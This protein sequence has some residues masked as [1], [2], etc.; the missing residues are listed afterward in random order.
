MAAPKHTKTL[1]VRVR[2]RHAPK[3]RAM[4]GHVNLVWNYCNELTDR[5]WRERRQWPS[6]FDLA[7]YLAGSTEFLQI[8]SATID[9]V[10]DVHGK[11]RRQQRKARLRWRGRRSLGWVPFK[12]RGARFRNGQVHFNGLAFKVWDSY[13]LSGYDF[14]AGAFVEDARGRWYFTV[15]VDVPE[16]YPVGDRQPIGIDLGASTTATP[17][18]GPKCT[19]TRPMRRSAAKLARIQRRVGTRKRGQRI[20]RRQRQRIAA[21][22]AKVANQRR[23]HLHKWSRALVDRASEVHVGNWNIEASKRLFGASI[24]DG[25]PAMLRGM[26]SYKCEHAGIPFSNTSEAYSTQAC[27]ACGS[28]SGPRGLSGLAVREWTCGDCGASHDRDRNAAMNIL[29]LGHQRLSP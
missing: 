23:D 24:H 25:A 6:A 7:P 5:M 16:S 3:L 14:R 20:G 19:N 26:L 21:C 22:H 8:G 29:A 27:S 12:S 28:L 10:R 15:A 11:S 9:E 17:S 4:A 18:T 1:K 13:G 2:D